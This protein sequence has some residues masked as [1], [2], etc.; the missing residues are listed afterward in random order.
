MERKHSSTENLFI[1]AQSAKPNSVLLL[2]SFSGTSRWS[3]RGSEFQQGNLQ[4]AEPIGSHPSF[5]CVALADKPNL[6][7][8]PLIRP[9]KKEDASS[10][11]CAPVRSTLASKAR[12]I[13]T[14]PCGDIIFI[15]AENK[16]LIWEIHSGQLLSQVEAHLRD[17]SAMRISSCGH[18]LVTASLDGDAKVFMTAN[19]VTERE[20]GLSS[21][22]NVSPFAVYSPHSLPITDLFLSGGAQSVSSLRILSVSADHSA[23]L[24]SLSTQQIL[25]R[26]T[27]DRPLTACCMDPAELRIFLATDSGSIR[28]LDICAQFSDHFVPFSSAPNSSSS[29]AVSSYIR[30]FDH[31]HNAQVSKLSV[32]ADGTRMASGDEKG[33]YSVW[34]TANGQCLL[35]G[36]MNG[37]ISALSFRRYWPTIDEPSKNDFCSSQWNSV[38]ILQRNLPTKRSLKMIRHWGG[39][40][41]ELAVKGVDEL[42]GKLVKQINSGERILASWGDGI[43]I[44]IGK[45]AIDG[46]RQ[47][48]SNAKSPLAKALHNGDVNGNVE[49]ASEREKILAKEVRCL[50]RELARVVQ[51]N[52]ELYNYSTNMVLEESF[53]E[54]STRRINN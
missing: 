28:S 42:L 38:A 11:R 29:P 54:K 2:D 4:T 7:I 43:G 8:I 19:L 13:Q 26:V 41:E 47:S 14:H 32:S 44:P 23:A 37:P 12:F 1:C 10:P 40:D 25:L 17:I 39:T 9:S 24:F 15:G 20:L 34:D 53:T 21:S 31:Q 27:A 35:S 22:A 18:F 51:L 30:R 48:I 46:K 16:L 52:A 5:L 3:L 36:A 33:C 45:K 49:I 50:R 6:Y